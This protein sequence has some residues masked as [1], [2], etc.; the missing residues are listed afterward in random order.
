MEIC[1]VPLGRTEYVRAWQLQQTLHSRC[2]RTGENIVLLTEHFPVV[3]LGY[4]RQAEQLRLSR[5]ELIEKEI[6]L[7]ESDRG[8]GATYHGPGQLVAYAIFSTL[9]RRHKVRLFISLLEEVMRHICARYDVA[10]DRKP[11]LPGVWVAQRKI[12]AV[13]I[14]VRGG[15]SL[16]GLALN[17]DL[18]LE[19][20]S[21]IVPCGLM[22]A[23]ITSLAQEVRHAIEMRDVIPQICRAFQEVFAVPVKER[24]NEWCC[25]E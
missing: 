4:R 3:T 22:D 20:F 18:A 1:A 9:F 11:G 24:T 19:P 25:V 15:T 23:E 7:V 12:G 14:A 2:Q 21:Y 5:S 16:H 10:A 17:V 13:G 8:G 6:T